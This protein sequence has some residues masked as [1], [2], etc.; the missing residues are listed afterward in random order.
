MW[1]SLSAGER[2]KAIPIRRNRA[3]S[4]SLVQALVGHAA[5]CWCDLDIPGSIGRISMAQIAS[6]L[7]VSYESKDFY[8]VADRM[9]Y[10]CREFYGSERGRTGCRFPRCCA[11]GQDAH[12]GCGARGPL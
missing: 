10:Y 3:V 12:P 9:S 1:F 6:K 8:P 7:C 5:V 4:R 2:T 11:S